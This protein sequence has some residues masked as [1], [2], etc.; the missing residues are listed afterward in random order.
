MRERKTYE[1]Q[2]THCGKAY[3]SHRHDSK[4]CGVTCRTNNQYRRRSELIDRLQA[5]AVQELTSSAYFKELTDTLQK[6]QT[7]LA[8]LQ[9]VR[10]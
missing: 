9:E 1:K 8:R 6:A 5:G 10:L 7:L 4:F 2:C 3:T